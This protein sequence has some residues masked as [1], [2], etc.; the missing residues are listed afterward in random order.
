[1]PA[2]PSR[3]R[4]ALL[5]L[6]AAAATAPTVLTAQDAYP[7]VDVRQ[8]RGTGVHSWANSARISIDR[9]AFVVVFEFGV[10]GRAR[11]LYPETPKDNGFLKASRKWYVPLP[12]ADA[13]SWKP[14]AP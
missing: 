11:V 13:F 12:S 10:D 9:D 5:L 4:G 2:F 6:A 1:M 8:I 7:Q 14:A 3:L